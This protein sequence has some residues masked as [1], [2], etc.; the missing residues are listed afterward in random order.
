MAVLQLACIGVGPQ[1]G[2]ALAHTDDHE[3]SLI[4]VLPQDDEQVVEWLA[5][6]EAGVAA[7]G[8]NFPVAWI[9][10]QVPPVPPVQQGPAEETPPPALSEP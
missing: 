10:Y 5:S 4:L 9:G 7:L 3:P 8:S 6:L 1:A 2:I